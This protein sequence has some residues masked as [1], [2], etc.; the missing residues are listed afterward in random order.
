PPAVAVVRQ[1][2]DALIVAAEY[3][4]FLARADVPD[5]DGAVMAGAGEG[6]V[7]AEGELVDVTLVPPDQAH[8]NA[9]GGVPDPDFGPLHTL[10]GLCHPAAAG[11]ELAVRADGDALHRHRVT[12]QGPQ[13]APIGRIV[14]LRHPIVAARDDPFAVGTEGH[15]HP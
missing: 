9:A 11:H 12:G 3:E 8:R 5:P 6:A 4:P 13:D 1:P 15:R 2:L 10:R 7:G 14:D